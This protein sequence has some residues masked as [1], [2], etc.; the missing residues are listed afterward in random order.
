M[1]FRMSQ[2]V[3]ANF[4]DYVAEILV[5]LGGTDHTGLD[6]VGTNTHAQIDTAIARLA[7][8]SGVNTGDE[9]TATI[10]AKLGISILTG[11]NT[12]DQD[13]SGYALI[14]A[15]P[16]SLSELANDVG[17]I[18]TETDPVVRWSDVVIGGEYL[19]DLG[20]GKHQYT[21]NGNE[22]Y[23]KVI[24]SP[25]SDKIYDDLALTNLIAERG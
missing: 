9:T 2:I 18:T 5:S 12:G 19:E 4:D 15:I 13:L 1:E 20:D 16:T 11:V 6:N 22:Y 10:K 17:F 7:D 25:H 21:Y 24:D 14:S 3:I 23:R 8:T